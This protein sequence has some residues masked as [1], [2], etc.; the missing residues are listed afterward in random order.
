METFTPSKA[1]LE[2]YAD[3]L[4][5]FALGRGKGIKKGEVVHLTA[6]EVAK[7]LVFELQKAI[8]KAGGHL[9]LNYRP[10]NDAE[11]NFDA[12]FFE[13]ASDHH[14][15]FFPTNYYQGLVDQIDH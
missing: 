3:V 4:V 7:P 1:I 10:S 2:R 9:I 15:D 13:N 12:V 8:L 6:P 14:L 5:N 11:Y